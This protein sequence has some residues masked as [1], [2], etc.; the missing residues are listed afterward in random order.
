MSDLDVEV[1]K[2]THSVLRENFFNTKNLQLVWENHCKDENLLKQ[3]ATAMKN[4]AISKWDVKSS[5]QDRIKWCIDICKEY[6]H[7]KGLLKQLQKDFRRFEYYMKD[8]SQFFC[9]PTPFDRIE[10]AEEPKIEVYQSEIKLLDV[11][12]CYNPFKKVERFQTIAIDLHPAT[13]DVYCADFLKLKFVDEKEFQLP[14]VNEDQHLTNLP[15]HHFQVV[16]FSLLLT[17]I[18]CPHTRWR[19]CKR[20]HQLLKT[21][22]LLLII[23]PDS[24]CVNKRAHLTQQWC[25]AI[26]Q[27]GFQRIHYSKSPHLH[28]FAFRKVPPTFLWDRRKFTQDHL[29]ILNIPQDPIL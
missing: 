24:N 17:Y 7:G 18:P 1:I 21:N 20:A 13:E 28:H 12:S 5:G 16:V 29:T 26:Q 3:Y 2:K 25:Q 22:G 23:T 10:V 8:K 6:F 27:I 19:M 11:G 14:Q 4:V 15:F 9:G